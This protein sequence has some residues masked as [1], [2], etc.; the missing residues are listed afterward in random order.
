MLV[1]ASIIYGH[2]ITLL[3]LLLTLCA[4]GES[5]HGNL[6]HAWHGRK[7]ISLALINH[8]LYIFL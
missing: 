7:V 2:K 4:R 1:I 6:V 5:D 8:E 3:S